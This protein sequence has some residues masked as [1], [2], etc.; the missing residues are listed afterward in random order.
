L[1]LF[2]GFYYVLLLF[3]PLRKE[4]KLIAMKKNYAVLIMVL[5]G[6]FFVVLIFF[7]YKYYSANQQ[8]KELLDKSKASDSVF[9][10]SERKSHELDSVIGAFKSRY[11]KLENSHFS[12][13][14][15]HVTPLIVES[16]SEPTKYR[17]FF[18]VLFDE[19]YSLQ[20]ELGSQLDTTNGELSGVYRTIVSK[21]PYFEY[22]EL[23]EADVHQPITGRIL[24]NSLT[25][26]RIYPIEEESV[27]R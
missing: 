14:V 22:F 7:G 27:W 21:P 4:L 24:V 12:V 6:V 19:M 15:K 23:D 13:F 26:N 1:G 18:I 8:N 3:I 25:T 2:L 16:K 10:V 11:D 20:L 5:L 9:L 17:V